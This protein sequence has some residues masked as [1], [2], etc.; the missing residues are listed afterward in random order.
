MAGARIR[1][2]VSATP[3]SAGNLAVIPGMFGSTAGS[4]LLPI[5]VCASFLERF[6][7]IVTAQVW[8]VG[9]CR[10]YISA[11][12]CNHE[13]GNRVTLWLNAHRSQ[14]MRGTV[15]Y[16]ILLPVNATSSLERHFFDDFTKI[17]TKGYCETFLVGIKLDTR[18]LLQTVVTAK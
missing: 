15:L 14:M 1:E 9:F 10:K 11:A 12:H 3:D 7:P 5:W 8:A 2:F 17:P 18:D 13:T 6:A 16:K 4:I